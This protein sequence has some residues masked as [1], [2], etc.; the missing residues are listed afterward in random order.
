[1]VLAGLRSFI[2]R[3]RLKAAVLRLMVDTLTEGEVESLGRTFAAMDENHDG[4]IT[5]PELQKAMTQ[6]ISSGEYKNYPSLCMW[7]HSFTLALRTLR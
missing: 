6:A 7:T 5:M 4:S 1:M 3:P 2:N